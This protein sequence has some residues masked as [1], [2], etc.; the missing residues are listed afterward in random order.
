MTAWLCP[1]CQQTEAGHRFINDDQGPGVACVF[2]DRGVISAGER[3]YVL[4]L[5][6]LAYE[7]H[8]DGHHV[9]S[10]VLVKTRDARIRTLLA[11]NED[12]VRRNSELTDLNS[13]LERTLIDTR[14]DAQQDL[15]TANIL[16]EDLRAHRCPEPPPAPP[17][18]APS[19][20]AAP[21]L[22]H[23][24]HSALA[25]VTEQLR[26]TAVSETPH[27]HHKNC[28][29]AA[30]NEITVKTPTRTVT[31]H[32]CENPKHVTQMYRLAEDKAKGARQ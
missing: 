8:R 25:E 26:Q 24:E 14:E 31:V 20:S 15:R 13:T 12:L 30:V 32:A 17:P 2:N 1:Y 10:D 29:H 18:A 16:I 9:C 3:D 27:C 11:T 5:L 28:N 19:A 22:T 6:G 23:D 4:S 21:L 7:A